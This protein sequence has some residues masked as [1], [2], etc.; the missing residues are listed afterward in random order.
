MKRFKLYRLILLLVMCNFCFQNYAY[1]QV[2][3]YI[4]FA[5]KNYNWGFRINN[6]TGEIVDITIV[7]YPTH[8]DGKLQYTDGLKIPSEINGVKVKSIGE[9]AFH[10]TLMYDFWNK[11][12]DQ[13][14]AGGK[15]EI[16]E[17]VESIGAGAFYF[18]KFTEIKLPST[19][20]SIGNFAFEQSELTNISM[21]ES[22]TE[23]GTYAFRSCQM[24]Y[25]S[26]GNT[27]TSIPGAFFSGWSKLKRITNC[28]N[29]RR[30]P[31]F[32]FWSSSIEEIPNSSNIT[33][34]GDYAFSSCP[35]LGTADLPQ[36]VN[37]GLE[38]FYES[39]LSDINIPN[40]KNFQGREFYGCLQLKSVNAP[41]IKEIPNEEFWGC[42]NLSYV[43]L[44][45]SL[46]TIGSS[47]FEGCTLIDGLSLGNV[48]SIGSKAFRNCSSL[49][50]AD[51]SSLKSISQSAFEG[52]TSLSDVTFK[53]LKSLGKSA[54]EGCTNLSNVVF[55]D[56]LSIIEESA[57]KDCSSLRSASMEN[58]QSLGKNAF[59]NCESLASP[60]TFHRLIVIP[61][62][63]FMG[64]SKIPEVAGD[65]IDA[66]ENS[67][68][69]NCYSL[70]S[71]NFQF[72]RNYS[73]YTN[74]NCFKGCKA[75]SKIIFK[76]SKI[77]DS[78]LY[79]NVFEGCDSIEEIT[80]PTNISI[81]DS[82]F[83]DRRFLKKLTFI[84]DNDCKIGNSAFEGCTSL[85]NISWENA[86]TATMGNSAF[87]GCT[88]LADFCCGKLEQIGDSCFE[89]CTA[90][91]TFS[92]ES[93]GLRQVADIGKYAF[94][95]CTSLKSVNGSWTK[96]LGEM[97]FLNCKSLSSIRDLY[98][99]SG[100]NI[101]KGC[102]S[103]KYVTFHGGDFV[104]CDSIFTDC[105]SLLYVKVDNAPYVFAADS[106]SNPFASSRI[107]ILNIYGNKYFSL[108][109]NIFD[110][111]DTDLMAIRDPYWKQWL[112]PDKA[113]L[114]TIDDISGINYYLELPVDSVICNDKY[115]KVCMNRTKPF[116]LRCK[117]ETVKTLGNNW[118]GN[119]QFD[120]NKEIESFTPNSIDAD[121]HKELADVYNNG[122]I[123]CDTLTVLSQ[124]S[125]KMQERI[126][127]V[128]GAFI[129]F[130]NLLTKA[131]L[132]DVQRLNI[133][134]KSI[135]SDIQNAK[136]I[137]VSSLLNECKE[138]YK[139]NED[140][141]PYLDAETKNKMDAAMSQTES[142]S[143]PDISIA[144]DLK[145]NYDC[146]KNWVE[147]YRPQLSQAQQDC[148]YWINQ[149]SEITQEEEFAYIDSKTRETLQLTLEL[150]KKSVSS[151]D[152]SVVTKAI[153]PLHQAYDNA[154]K[155]VLSISGELAPA[156]SVLQTQINKCNDYLN[157]KPY[158][159][160][161]DYLTQLRSGAQRAEAAM[162]TADINS[163][164]QY[165]T[166]LNT[167]FSE[168]DADIAA[169]KNKVKQMQDSFARVFALMDTLKTIGLYD[170]A[171]ERISPSGDL[172]EFSL[173][174]F[175]GASNG[176]NKCLQTIKSAQGLAAYMGASNSGFFEDEVINYT[177]KCTD[178]ISRFE[179]EFAS[180][181]AKYQLEKGKL[182]E[183]IQRLQ[184]LKEDNPTAYAKVDD[185]LKSRVEAKLTEWNVSGYAEVG[186]VYANADFSICDE[187]QQAVGAYESLKENLSKMLAN[188]SKD[189]Q[190]IANGANMNDVAVR[191]NYRVGDGLVTQEDQVSVIIGGKRTLIDGDG[192]TKV[193]LFS[194]A[195]TIDLDLTKECCNVVLAFA[196]DE[197]SL[198]HHFKVY[199]TNNAQDNSSWKLQSEF[200]NTYSRKISQK[201]IARQFVGLDNNYRYLRIEF[202]PTDECPKTTI[203]ELRVY[204]RA[205]KF[206]SE[207]A[208]SCTQFFRL[209]AELQA[210]V[211]NQQEPSLESYEKVSAAYARFNAFEDSENFGLADFKETTAATYFNANKA[212]SLP[213]EVAGSIITGKNGRIV[214]D[215]RF[216]ETHP[217]PANTAV[218]LQGEGG[219]SYYLMPTTDYVASVEGNLLH[220]MSADGTTQ[221][222]ESE[223]KYYK[224]NKGTFAWAKENGAAFSA[225]A[226]DVFLAIPAGMEQLE[227]YDFG[228]IYGIGDNVPPYTGI[229][230]ISVSYKRKGIYDLNGRPINVKDSRE[231]MP[232][233]YIVDGKKVVV[234]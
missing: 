75:L 89:G 222:T 162:N 84:N 216:D 71:V 14:A 96:R 191:S 208:D 21:P 164:R 148:Q 139:Q 141:L 210:Q 97:A 143:H 100:K 104:K 206:E 199:A 47:A 2:S 28:A 6:Q 112:L 98:R 176:Y 215:T 115:K 218:V 201:Y 177:N 135:L 88:S 80:L 228:S 226:G 106:L 131:S 110:K 83:I 62:Q 37:L 108:Y 187:L 189:C 3:G 74:N 230:E 107:P 54:F 118:W 27:R 170:Q 227:S 22:L 200:V 77:L 207:G 31:Q 197:S 153:E 194:S 92:A 90:L 57:F 91:R 73:C 219:C 163:I 209:V 18:C 212:V 133:S 147:Q 151:N 69:E 66:I 121:F 60:L 103:L 81:S 123:L 16:P 86:A 43:V 166:T 59:Q 140:I 223:A 179:T 202:V 204:H 119:F 25:F 114:L 39:S 160:T 231:L 105:K 134:I 130:D 142:M 167:L 132:E 49:K 168:I 30:I 5:G 68:F 82:T 64:C 122:L 11:Q 156:K 171:G 225:K 146:I 42:K 161:A 34:I 76:G 158:Y 13:Y 109:R 125:G 32:A 221:V 159:F 12:L 173:F 36:L 40:I 65:S 185:N 45:E 24:E 232:G 193:T 224:F 182:Q 127:S 198:E 233:I 67:A 46:K 144:Y 195:K 10:T 61:E 20:K 154:S 38:S 192:D 116:K 63:A 234:K 120:S 55:G 48:E 72:Y 95:N 4:Y 85:I 205:N 124:W 7:D 53:E 52:C 29:L 9:K 93:A 1:G 190:T 44:S 213:H 41:L 111:I 136:D 102:T 15:L 129:P 51:L 58:I 99:L 175:D 87:K 203:S 138:L 183:A 17:G 50:T 155:A 137:D 214:R 23:C 184:S 150:A 196:N 178:F 35:H 172:N 188:I 126:D 165:I 78:K 8:Y 152:L 220:G 180:L 217:V 33:E 128:M 113:P 211:D 101:F 229:G 145:Y 181:D 174:T 79:K 149:A 19:L 157:D 26:L 94:A 186:R 117:D 169:N 56:S 70:S